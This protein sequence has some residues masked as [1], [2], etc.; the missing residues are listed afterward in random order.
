MGDRFLKDLSLSMSL[1]QPGKE[2]PDIITNALNYLIVSFRVKD[3]IEKLTETT[4]EFLP[5]ELINLKGRVE[6]DRYFIVNI[7]DNEPYTVESDLLKYYRI[8]TKPRVDM[9][10]CFL[11]NTPEET[12]AYTYKMSWG[13]PV[14]GRYPENA[15]VYMDER[16]P[17]TKLPDLIGTVRSYLIVSKKFKDVI[18]GLC[19]KIE[20][21]YLPLSIYDHKKKLASDNYFIINPIGTIDVMN[22]DKAD[23]L[24]QGDDVVSIKKFIFDPEKLKDEPHLFRVKEDPA[25]YFISQELA[26]ELKKASISNLFTFEVE[27]QTT[28]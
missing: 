1:D 22:R 26:L 5:F 28:D 25:Y 11:R 7:L 2:V 14:T 21:E 6:K 13:E 8:N 16:N 15:I 10:N 9:S 24:Y 20:I 27:V 12:R 19:K 18:E 3:I 23:I 17:G 4:V